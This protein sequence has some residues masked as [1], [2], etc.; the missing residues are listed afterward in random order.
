MDNP[1]ISVLMTAYNREKY[2]GE[3]IESVL[4]S[5]FQNWELI[6][7]DDCSKDKTVEI[8]HSYAE[9][10]ERINVYINK[11]NL[12]DYPNRNKA[13]SYAKGRYLK[14]LDSDDVIYPH[15]LEIYSYYMNKFPKAALGLNWRFLQT[16]GKFPIFL[17]PEEAIK[18]HFQKGLF[19][20]APGS[21]IIRRDKF[22]E[23]GGFSGIRQIG[24]YE[25]WLKLASRFP[26]L[27]ISFFPMWTRTHDEQE[28]RV[29]SEYEKTIMKSITNLQFLESDN[30]IVNNK[31]KLK[32]ISYNKKIIFK[33]AIKIV[34]KS[35]DI[36]GATYYLNKLKIRNEHSY[37]CS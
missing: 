36:K 11:Q 24:D 12:G 32:L 26:V 22:E 37:F 20:N 29:N 5:T 10:D 25:C 14:Y 16:E 4:A 18:Q 34:L 28:L 6:I 3:A 31:E 13:A 19:H 1:E 9:K 33:N 30:C 27:K 15:A 2:I 35:F 21:V 8:A 7:V 23:I 17:Q